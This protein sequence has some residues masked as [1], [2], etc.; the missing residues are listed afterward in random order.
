MRLQDHKNLSSCFL[1]ELWNQK[2]VSIIDELLADNYVDHTPPRRPG[3][4]ELGPEGLRRLFQR[5]Q[6]IFVD[7]H[8]AIEDQI[9]QEDRVVT[10]L[11]WQITLR[12]DDPAKTP[13]V[14]VMGIS[15]DRIHCGKI[16]ENW[17]MLDVL[18]RL[19]NLLETPVTEGNIPHPS[20]APP[21]DGRG[22]CPPH[23]L[24]RFGRCGRV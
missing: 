6:R 19:L 3:G 20:A 2:N 16:V 13:Q 15:I 24:C 4:A 21:C 9:A 12:D 14:T 18:Y 1:E 23:C 10:R 7:I 11:T 5:L 8:V 17:N 22:H